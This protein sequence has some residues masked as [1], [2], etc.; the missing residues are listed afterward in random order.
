MLRLTAARL[1]GSDG[2]LFVSGVDLDI[3]TKVARELGWK[4]IQDWLEQIHEGDSSVRTA[5]PWHYSGLEPRNEQSP[6]YKIRYSACFQLGGSTTL[7]CTFV[8]ELGK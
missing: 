7:K 2:F 8:G 5:W 6:D 3:R 4:P 1:N